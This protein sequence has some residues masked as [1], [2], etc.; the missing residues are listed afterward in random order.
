MLDAAVVSGG[1]FDDLRSGEQAGFLADGNKADAGPD[2]HGA[3]EDEATRLEA[4][5]LCRVGA[6]GDACQVLHDRGQQVGVTEQSPHVRVT[7]DPTERGADPLP[8]NRLGHEQRMPYR[9]PTFDRM[10]RPRRYRAA[11]DALSRPVALRLRTAGDEHE[12]QV[13]SVRRPTD[14]R[15]VEA[16][17]AQ[18]DVDL[19]AIAEPQRRVGGQH[20]AFIAELEGRPERHER[21]FDCRD[22][23]PAG[24]AADAG[25]GH[26]A[27]A[28]IAAPPAPCECSR[29]SR[30]E[31]EPAAWAQ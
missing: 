2:G 5:D 12:L 16:G 19:V 27:V 11:A 10:Y 14:F 3:T 17:D 22:P 1:A 25:H 23:P 28:R 21:E 8:Q 7:V 31:N 4:G 20:R 18:R 9:S 26:R 24:Q 30:L 29:I 6:G 13:R 15:F